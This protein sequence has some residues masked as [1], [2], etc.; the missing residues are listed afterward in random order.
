MIARWVPLAQ[1]RA[2]LFAGDLHSPLSV[3]G[4][5]AATRVLVDGDASTRPVASPWFRGG[6][7]S[8]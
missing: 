5:L 7:P 1:A 6:G 8:S 3:M 2:G 4:I